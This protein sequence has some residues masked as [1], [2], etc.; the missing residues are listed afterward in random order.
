MSWVLSSP[1]RLRQQVNRDLARNLPCSLATS[2]PN[3]EV[4]NPHGELWGQHR[5]E[6]LLRSCSHGTPEQIIHCILDEV[7]SFAD[8]QKQRGDMTLVVMIVQEGCDL[9]DSPWRGVRGARERRRR[10]VAK[11]HP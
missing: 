6:N 9:W 8:G 1:V 10:C 11:S 3:A 5:L 7:S 2:C 4:E